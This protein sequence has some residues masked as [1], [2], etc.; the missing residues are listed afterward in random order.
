[1][2]AFDSILHVEPMRFRVVSSC[3]IRAPLFRDK[4]VS[5][6][7]TASSGVFHLALP[8]VLQEHCSLRAFPHILSYLRSL[9]AETGY[10]H[11]LLPSL[12]A[13][14]DFMGLPG[15]AS[16][17]LSQLRREVSLPDLPHLCSFCLALS[18]ALSR[19][20][21]HSAPS[22]PCRS[23][24]P[25]MQAVLG[26]VCAVTGRHL[27]VDM[28]RG[29]EDAL[30][31]WV[32][33]RAVADRRSVV[34][35]EIHRAR[36]A[37]VI[38]MRQ[39]QMAVR[40]RAGAGGVYGDLDSAALHVSVRDPIQLTLRQRGYLLGAVPPA[41]RA[42][43]QERAR[44]R[45]RDPKAIPVS[46][47][48]PSPSPSPT[49]HAAVSASSANNDIRSPL[50]AGIDAAVSPT[51]RRDPGSGTSHSHT[52]HE[53]QED[54]HT[55]RYVHTLLSA[56]RDRP[57]GSAGTDTDRGLTDHGQALPS[58]DPTAYTR[59]SLSEAGG[60]CNDV[61]NGYPVD[62]PLSP[63][64]QSPRAGASDVGWEGPRDPAVEGPLRLCLDG[65]R[66]GGLDAEDLGEVEGWGWYTPD[67]LDQVLRY[68][69]RRTC[70]T[71]TSADYGR[72]KAVQQAVPFF[73]GTHMETG[74][75]TGAGGGLCR[76]PS[77]LV[78]RDRPLTGGGIAVAGSVYTPRLVVWGPAHA[79]QLCLTLERVPP[80]EASTA[81][82][83]LVDARPTSRLS[84]V[85]TVHCVG[86]EER[87]FSRVHTFTPPGLVRQRGAGR[88]GPMGVSGSPGSPLPL[89]PS[90]RP[91]GSGPLCGWVLGLV[92]DCDDLFVTVHGSLAL[93]V[94]VEAMAMPSHTGTGGE[95]L[96]Q[97]VGEGAV[98]S[99]SPG[100]TGAARPG[101]GSDASKAQ[102]NNIMDNYVSDPSLLV[103]LPRDGPAE[104]MGDRSR[105][106]S[107][108]R[109]A[110]APDLPLVVSLKWHRS[111]REQKERERLRQT[112]DGT[113]EETGSGDV[114][115][116]TREK[117]E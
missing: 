32:L 66:L 42:R 56:M 57:L 98:M 88:A 83:G 75:G 29:T 112:E 49:G 87:R 40:R 69:F 11:H 23:L 60:A 96:G 13:F 100:V 53:V 19:V 5:G 93:V 27:L 104:A 12:I 74:T 73:I 41:H 72:D 45:G 113:E 31:L 50:P 115:G 117:K 2:P 26:V 39:H 70:G 67:R 94:T 48:P 76:A 21:S 28:A 25:S 24:Y 35:T 90:A 54:R 38:A 18:P 20:V 77:Q 109:Q 3:L 78:A 71:L 47:L 62:R 79:E 114:G 80:S 107:P 58:G 101:P 116:E 91:V 51:V 84:L 110:C 89:S 99:P 92:R 97:S 10:P 4:L 46:P 30:P 16:A 37:V 81:T 68:Q 43:A 103:P 33:A 108:F 8:L 52:A 44:A 55:Q 34:E 95:G 65:I 111:Y 85:V 14:A 22:P 6:E 9:T 59:H 17:C 36:G 7:W 64:L 105:S 106:P 86:G 102:S 15:L 63:S 61:Y 1:M 82:Q